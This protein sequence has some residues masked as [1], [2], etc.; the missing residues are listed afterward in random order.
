MGAVLNY[1]EV[2]EQEYDRLAAILRGHMDMK[3]IYDM[4]GIVRKADHE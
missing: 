4:L 1:A 2:K 3:L